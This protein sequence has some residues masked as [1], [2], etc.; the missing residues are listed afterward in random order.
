MTGNAQSAAFPAMLASIAPVIDRFMPLHLW[1]SKDGSVLHAGPTL[2][3]VLEDR[4]DQNAPFDLI[5]DLRR[6]S[7]ISSFKDLAKSKTE[8]FK[9]SLKSEPSLSF[10]AVSVTLPEDGGVVFNLSPGS[11][12]LNFLRRFDLTLA[13]FSPT[14]FTAEMLF[15]MEANATA[16]GEARK[17]NVR[18]EG[19][20]QRAEVQ[21][22]TDTLTGL[23]NRRA[24]D[25]A[26]KNAVNNP[27]HGFGVMHIDLDYFKTVN[28]S[29]GH[30]GGDHVLLQVADILKSETRQ[31]D[32]VAR[33]GGDE[34]LMLLEGCT[35][36]EML[37][38]IATRI[39]SRL[40]RPILFEGKTCHISASIGTTVSDFY[41][42]L[43]AEQIL[44]DADRATY[45]SKKQGRGRHTI[46]R[47][48]GG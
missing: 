12:L 43:A 40:E 11:D 48:S 17:L 21:A 13:D 7:K 26:L 9:V 37:D 30:S 41:D 6:P 46:F 2:K 18:L 4:L 36:L 29:L 3:K 16:L 34:F 10:K 22:Q 19:A 47:S 38:K 44:S 33:V 28:D 42:V 20:K 45:T 25:Q 15:L 27:K 24:M 35:E 23:Q 39:I 1:A 8:R 14:D 5:F 31:Q 32:T